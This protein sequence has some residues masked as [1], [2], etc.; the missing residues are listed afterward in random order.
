MSMSEI[1][2]HIAA[3]HG[4]LEEMDIVEMMHELGGV[5]QI[6]GGGFAVFALFHID[7]MHGGTGGAEMDPGA[8]QFQIMLRDRGQKA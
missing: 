5:Q 6:L 3:D 8:G 4:A 2:R 7:H 1:V